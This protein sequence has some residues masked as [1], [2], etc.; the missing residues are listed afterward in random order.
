MYQEEKMPVNPSFHR[1]TDFLK[2]EKTLSPSKER[3]PYQKGI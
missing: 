1:R 3:L 2:I